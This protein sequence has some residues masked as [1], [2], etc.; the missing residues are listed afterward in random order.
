MTRRTRVWLIQMPNASDQTRMEFVLGSV[1]PYPADEGKGVKRAG[2][3]R[4]KAPEGQE[5]LETVGLDGRIGEWALLARR[6]G[7]E[8]WVGAMTDWTAR[9]IEVPLSF[10]G[11]GGWDATLW[12]DGANADKV[13]T[14]DVLDIFGVAL[15]VIDLLEETQHYKIPEELRKQVLAKIQAE[16]DDLLKKSK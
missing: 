9:T 2:G 1:R 7:D 11:G 12:T 10:A 14:E 3:L 13:G 5:L 6:K 15:R 4:Q 16:L 8:W